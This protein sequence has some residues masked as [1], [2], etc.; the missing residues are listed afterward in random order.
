MDGRLQLVHAYIFGYGLVSCGV[1]VYVMLLFDFL[2][3]FEFLFG[4]VVGDEEMGR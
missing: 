2:C 4:V 1:C 3:L